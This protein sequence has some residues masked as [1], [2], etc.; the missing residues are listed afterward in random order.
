MT[1]FNA[2]LAI[3]VLV[4]VGMIVKMEANEGERQ[5]RKLAN[6]FE[7]SDLDKSW[8]NG[9]QEKET[10]S[11]VLDIKALTSLGSLGTERTGFEPADQFPSHRFS[12]PTLS[13][14]QPP[15]LW[16]AARHAYNP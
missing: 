8:T 3:T 15:L 12:K 2:L 13:T 14:T 4:I 16:G 10:G 7:D 11:Q 5:A 1:K 9:G 6:R